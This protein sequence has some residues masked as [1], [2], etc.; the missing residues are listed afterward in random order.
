MEIRKKYEDTKAMIKQWREDHFRSKVIPF[1]RILFGIGIL[2]KIVEFIKDGG[3]E[4]EGILYNSTKYGPW[5][6]AHW[7]PMIGIAAALLIASGLLTRLASLVLIPIFL[8]G[9]VLGGVS[10]VF[11]AFEQS[12]FVISFILLLGCIFFSI[13]G[14]GYYSADRALVDENRREEEFFWRE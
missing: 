11:S 9:I 14:S 1:I 2:F 10:G 7:V 12:H 4:I 6:F 5:I 3:G 13:Y 8:G